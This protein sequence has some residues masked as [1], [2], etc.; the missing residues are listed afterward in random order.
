MRGQSKTHVVAIIQARMGSTRLPGKTLVDIVGKPLLGHVIERVQACQTIEDIVVAT[1]TAVEDQPILDLA[2][3]YGV[4][5]YTGSEEDVL[6]RFYQAAI[7]TSA[8]VIVRITADDPFKD[9]Q[10]I[11][12]IVSYFLHHPE[13]DYASNTVEPTYPEGLDVEVFSFK[14]L[15]TAWQEAQ[16]LSDR[17]H[18]TP[19]I[20]RNPQTFCIANIKHH[21]D[22]SHLRWTLDYEEDLHFTRAVYEHLYGG[23]VFL[24]EDILILLQK[25]PQLAGINKG[26]ER[27]IGYQKSLVEDE[28]HH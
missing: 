6:D 16:R 21:T 3:Q 27:N 17:E 8:E 5:H 7:N 14:A 10:V 22:L 19:Y 1:T 24:M 4:M 15:E 2:G 28:H 13:L 9:P 23:K 26:I 18:V 11:D 20:W 25:E 12:H